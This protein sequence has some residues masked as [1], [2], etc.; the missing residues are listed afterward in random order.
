MQLLL[1]ALSGTHFFLLK[2]AQDF[3]HGHILSFQ[4]P[5]SRKNLFLVKK[6]LLGKKIKNVPGFG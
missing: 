4:A 5:F 2:E 1:L 6:L 3:F